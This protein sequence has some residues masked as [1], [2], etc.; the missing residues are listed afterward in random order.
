[1][2]LVI[3]VENATIL[4]NL[5]YIVTDN[6]SHCLIYINS[7]NNNK[8]HLKK[9]A[10]WNECT[11]LEN[12]AQFLDINVARTQKMFEKEYQHTGYYRDTNDAL[13]TWTKKKNE[14]R[15]SRIE[16]KD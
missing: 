7:D 5:V 12:K 9:H 4:G 13:K 16:L 2:R 1:M 10:N 8:N 11:N 14:T 15:K 6:Y 3:F